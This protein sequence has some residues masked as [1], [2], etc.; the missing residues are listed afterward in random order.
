MW[1]SST[2]SFC[3]VLIAMAMMEDAEITMR[4]MFAFIAHY[5]SL[6]TKKCRCW[7]LFRIALSSKA[8]FRSSFRLRSVWSF[9]FGFATSPMDAFASAHSFVGALAHSVN[10]I[11]DKRIPHSSNRNKID[12]RNMFRWFSMFN[13]FIRLAKNTIE[14]HF[15][16]E[17]CSR[18]LSVSSYSA[19]TLEMRSTDVNSSIF[20]FVSLFV[21]RS[22]LEQSEG[23]RG[24]WV[25]KNGDT[26]N[27]SFGFAY[28]FHSAG[29]RR[30]HRFI[31]T[32]CLHGGKQQPARYDDLEQWTT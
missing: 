12:Y 11:V 30:C 5:S 20:S 19:Y 6:G 28:S 9:R 22:N 25:K 15:D 32:A 2:T 3:C 18:F 7:F 8:D 10:L 27:L 24:K 31:V 23:E 14:I 21:A 4:P 26:K 29:N 17:K 16:C 13:R 1:W